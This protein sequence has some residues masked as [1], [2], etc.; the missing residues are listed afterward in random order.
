MNN[1][2]STYLKHKLIATVTKSNLLVFSRFMLI[3]MLSPTT[4]LGQTLE[5]FKTAASN[6]EG[7]NLIPFYEL[8]RDATSIADEVQ[9]RKSEVALAKYDD[10]KPQK[11]NILNTIKKQMELIKKENEFMAQYKVVNPDGS[12]DCIKADVTKQEG[13]IAENNDKRIKL[14][15]K[16]K[17]GLDAFERLSTARG[18]L[19]EYFDDALKLLAEAQANPNKYIGE[20]PSQIDEPTS[21]EGEP[22][23]EYKRR[24]EEYKEYKLKQETYENDK[25]SLEN[26]VADI[27]Q[28]IQGQVK[29]HLEQENGSLLMK[30][31]FEELLK[32]TE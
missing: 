9:N 25:G 32:R 7:P 10:W 30:Q 28:K 1:N 31:Q 23:D 29:N 13:I 8:R 3:S 6:N 26:Y 19:R 24:L 22:T 14:D 17:S 18:G 12:I 21:P 11:E 27:V 16:I 2:K 20:P 15:E 5:D 4:M